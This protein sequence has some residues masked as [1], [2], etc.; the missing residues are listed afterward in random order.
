MPV[1]GPE[2]LQGTSAPVPIYY[3]LQETLRSKIEA[4]EWKPGGAIPPERIIAEAYGASVGTVKKALQNLVNSGYL[5]RVQGKGTFVAGTTLRKGSLRY[6]R[7]QRALDDEPADL[8]IRFLGIRETAGAADVKR[9]LGLPAKERL[10]EL[11]RLFLW[12]DKPVVYSVS[13]LPKRLFKDLN[14][15][16]EIRLKD[17]TLYE[18]IEK[19]YGLPTLRNQ[20]LF[21]AAGAGAA[22]AEALAVPKGSPVLT[23]EMLSFTYRDVPYEY[24]LSYCVTTER[25]IFSEI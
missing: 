14:R 4:G 9:N 1:M 10:F 13:S 17:R 15:L 5:I 22:A 2:K 23:I 12:G 6:Y 24:R 18:T 7:M 21:G 3:R 11:R 25:K 20:E 8:T 19:I 16:P